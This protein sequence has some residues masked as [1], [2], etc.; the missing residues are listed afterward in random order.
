M[1]W[2]RLSLFTNVTRDPAE[3]VVDLGETPLDVIVI[4]APL[5]EGEGDGEGE[6]EPPP[7]PPHPAAL[8]ANARAMTCAGGTRSPGQR[9]TR[10][11][12]RGG[13]GA[14]GECNGVL[15]R[16]TSSRC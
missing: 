6:G 16:R 4:V 15:I 2:D 5:D 9:A 10:P 1:S 3:T 11:R 13:A 7:P 8:S 12:Q 14:A